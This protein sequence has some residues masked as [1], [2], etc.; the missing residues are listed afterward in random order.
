MND[1]S[2][3]L[4]CKCKQQKPATEFGKL[5]TSPDGLRYDCKHCRKEYRDKNIAK[6]K[7]KQREYYNANKDTL[8]AKN[9]I[10]R[11][12]NRDVI[13]EQRSEYRSRPEI[14]LH[15]KQKNKEY[16]PIKKEKIRN[17]RKTDL[18]FRI[19]EVIRSKIYKVLNGLPTSYTNILGCDYDFLKKWIE[20]RFDPTM[21]WENFGS[22][23]QIDHILP[24]SKF[25]FSIED[26]L[27]ICFHWT[28][29]QP[30]QSK[31][32]RSKYNNFELHYYFNNL[33]NI[34]R[35]NQVH[36]QFLGYQ[37]VSKSLQWLRNELRYGKNAPYEIDANQSK[38]AI[39]SQAPNLANDKS[40]EKVQRLNSF[41]H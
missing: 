9:A 21:N 4:C 29:L 19:S 38:L 33:V 28:N 13:N 26:N 36:T 6:I 24:I 31:I 23:W 41:G 11:E 18:N 35:F 39:R 20:F 32:N 30:L 5:K 3:K 10:Y 34:H 40:M 17:R 8:L 37:T 1:L 2:M 12:N 14:K 22:V 16:L 7:E 25:D 27:H 15:V